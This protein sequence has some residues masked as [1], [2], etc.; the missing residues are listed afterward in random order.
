MYTCIHLG[1]AIFKLKLILLSLKPCWSKSNLKPISR[2]PHYLK[3]LLIPQWLCDLSTKWSLVNADNITCTPIFHI[4]KNSDILRCRF[5]GRHSREFWK[6]YSDSLRPGDS[7][8]LIFGSHRTSWASLS[9]VRITYLFTRVAFQHRKPA[10]NSRIFL[11]SFNDN[12][13]HTPDSV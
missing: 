2:L 10:W 5:V 8:H 3:S 11:S 12:V 13:N 1:A 9:P 4:Y 6:I 7:N